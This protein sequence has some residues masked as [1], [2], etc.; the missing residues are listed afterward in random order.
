MGTSKKVI[1]GVSWTTLQTLINRGA[2]FVVKMILARILFPEDYGL[3]GMA[4]VFAGFFKVITD[5]GF[6]SAIIQR[7]EDVLTKK[8]LSTAY[9]TNFIWSTFIYLL[10]IFGIAPFA[11]Q[12]YNEPILIY[13]IPIL[14]ISI[15]TTPLFYIQKSLL[16]RDLSFKK[17]ALI[18][19]SGSLIGGVIAIFMAFTGFGV[20]ALVAQGFFQTIIELFLYNK[21]VKW[22]ASLEWDINCFKDIFGFGAFTTLSALVYKFSTEGINLFIGKILGKV[23]LGLY[24]F[25]YI[26]TDSIRVQIRQI[27]DVVMYPIYSKSQ[28]DKK[29]QI[30]FLEK[31][32]FFN[33]L[34]LT[35]IMGFLF[36]CTEMVTFIF[37]EK[38]IESLVI[39]KIISVSVVVQTVTNSFSTVFRAN[40]LN[41]VEFKLQLIKVFLIF[42]PIVFLGTY[43]YGIVGSSYGVLIS[44]IIMNQVNLYAFKKYLDIPI[45]IL[46]KAF[47]KG[48]LPTLISGIIIYIVF[49][50]LKENIS[51]MLLK[52][53]L[54]I[55]LTIM[56]TYILEKNT[57]LDLVRKIG[58]K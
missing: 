43:Y 18:N 13:I 53:F 30:Y 15:I 5:L 2:G 54:M 25:A 50:F 17:I 55:G 56:L 27:I 21:N 49:Y 1:S 6:G 9:W 33:S 57:I 31:S 38:W 3:I 23:E 58:K 37:G 14:G 10:L 7:K 44:R 29:T 20:W 42:S 40:N 32:V 47:I 8:Y 4:I 11:S 41:R 26:L 19:N 12:F 46:N 48:L 52:S 39:I 24:S 16:T 22:K 51:F 35:P 45:N 28:D 36:V 34:I